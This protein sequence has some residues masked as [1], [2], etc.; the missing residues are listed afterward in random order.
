MKLNK[1][2]KKGFTLVEL[3]VVIAIIAILSAVTI[4]GYYGFIGSAK[5]SAANQEANQIKISILG[6]TS[7]SGM[8]TDKE[9]SDDD[10][11]KIQKG[12]LIN[13]TRNGVRVT[14]S[15]LSRVSDSEIPVFTATLAAQ[16]V[17]LMFDQANNTETVTDLSMDAITSENDKV[18]NK[19]A[20]L[21]ENKIEASTTDKNYYLTTFKYV[22]KDGTVSDQISLI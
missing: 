16:L 10:G 19:P 3:I 17:V 8:K 13:F 15:S 6:I 9:L 1:K 7:G 22:S 21:V 5:K 20:I 4:T 11:N 18:A 14:A 2:L 12:E